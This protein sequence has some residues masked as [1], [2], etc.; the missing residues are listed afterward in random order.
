M[1]TWKPAAP[2]RAGVL[3]A[4]LEL[5]AD[6]GIGATSLQMIADRLGVT[7]AAV[8]HHFRTK[9]DIVITALRPGLDQ[10]AAAVQ[11]AESHTDQRARAGTVI[12]GMAEC[13][14][15]NRL[16][17][18]VMMSDPTA[19]R[20]LESDPE[21]AEL[22]ER[23][24]RALGGP[25]PDMTTRMAVACFLSACLGPATDPGCADSTDAELRAAVLNAG[26]RLVLSCL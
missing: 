2:G 8:Y 21:L 23:V 4:A 3:A 20:L 11:L 12:A 16:G 1:V 24:R 10:L 6:R 18:Q 13:L 17:Y 25:D 19:T 5:F 15:T 26:E 9:A 22:F 14:V 7:K